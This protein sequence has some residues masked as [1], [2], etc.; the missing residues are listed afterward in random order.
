MELHC[1]TKM[2]DMDGVSEVKDIIK[3]AKSWGMPAIAVTDH[4]CVQS[5]PDANHALD[6]GDTFKILYG[7]EGYLVDDLKQ[8]V[9][10]SRGQKLSETYVVFDLETTGLSSKHD[11]IIEIGAVKVKDGVIT[12]KYSTFVNPRIPIPY[13]IEDLTKISDDMVME[14]PGIEE[15]LPE[16]LS[17]CGDSVLVAH[18]AGFDVGFIVQN[19]RNLGIHIKPTVLDTVFLAQQLMPNLGKYKLNV[20]AKALGV[21]LENHHR[22]VEDAGATAEIFAIFVAMLKKMGIEDLD[23]LNDTSQISLHRTIRSR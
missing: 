5:F 10:N 3:R 19:A 7:V 13:E 23:Q 12:D 21:S 22:A 9:E 8:P 11:R 2:S 15:V 18:N 16:F 14:A 6:K 4:G 1:H 17:F 20:V